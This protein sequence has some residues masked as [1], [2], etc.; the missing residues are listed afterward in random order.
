MP[1]KSPKYFD[2]DERSRIWIRPDE[3]LRLELLFTD[4]DITQ[5][6]FTLKYQERRWS[7][8]PASFDE[9]PEGSWASGDP[10]FS[11]SDL[12]KGKLRIVVGASNMMSWIDR[13]MELRLIADDGT[14]TWAVTDVTVT[15]AQGA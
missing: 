13:T 5:V 12:P 11:N 14:D 4:L 15:V 2:L 10:E 8:A 7:T 6:D 3:D 1:Q 9:A